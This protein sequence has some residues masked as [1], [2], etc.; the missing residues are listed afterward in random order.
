M[1]EQ[2]EIG[3]V[4]DRC[5]EPA[6]GGDIGESGDVLWCADHAEEVL[7]AIFGS[8]AATLFLA[9][10]EARP[11]DWCG[12]DD[13]PSSI[14]NGPHVAHVCSDGS[15]VDQRYDNPESCPFGCGWE[16]PASGRP[17]T[18]EGSTS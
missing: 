13:C 4:C 16:P 2:S 1:G 8:R 9:A 11:S 6:V 17:I 10:A 15:I 7:A 18:D 14:C 3:A 5:E 12:V